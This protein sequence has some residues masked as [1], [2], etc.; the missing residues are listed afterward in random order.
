MKKLALVLSMLMATPAFADGWHHQHGGYYRGG[1]Y[2]W[3]APLIIGGA[4]GYALTQPRTVYVQPQPPV[5]YQYPPVGY[6]Y[7]TI[8]DAGCNCY[9]NVLVQN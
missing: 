3:V 4:V 7:E 1:N 5:V 8:L 9:R 6:H 2:N